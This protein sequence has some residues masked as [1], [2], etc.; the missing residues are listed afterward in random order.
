MAVWG[1]LR[2]RGAGVAGGGEVTS[3]REEGA[4]GGRGRG[5]HV[6]L[7]VGGGIYKQG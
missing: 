5:M 1:S 2:S 4:C 6:R 7:C 3:S